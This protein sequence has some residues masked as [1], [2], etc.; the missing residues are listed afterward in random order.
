MQ[1]NPTVE[2]YNRYA[3]TYDQEVIEFWDNFPAN[4]IDAFV[5]SLP[6]GGKRILN[7]G[8]GSGR[9][10]MLLRE[11]GL[12]VV[13]VDAS[14]T[15]VETTTKLGFDSHLMTFAD[16]DFPPDSFDGIWAYTSLIHIPK[17]E[18]ADTIARLRPLLRRDGAFAIGVIEG[19][20][21]GMVERKTMPGTARYFK[22][23]DRDELR[24]M[25]APLGYNLQYE[26]DYR[27]HNS[28]YLNQLYVR[29]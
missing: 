8:S 13:C 16:V 9:D 26:S 10:A 3:Q 6:G 5:A 17:N 23:Y 20:A 28:V 19:D 29:A 25:I 2:T 15:M 22:N 1:K 27:P 24:Q 11:R 21:A 12:D 7:V 14:S 18:A 4:F